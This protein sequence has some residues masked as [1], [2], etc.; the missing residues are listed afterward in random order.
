MVTIIKQKRPYDCPSD[1]DDGLLVAHGDISPGQNQKE[2]SVAPEVGPVVL[3]RAAGFDDKN[4]FLYRDG[5]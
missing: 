2:L 4:R 1:T 3:L 5:E